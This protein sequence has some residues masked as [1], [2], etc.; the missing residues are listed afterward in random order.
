MPEQ[1]LATAADAVL[2][3]DDQRRL[4]DGNDA[5][6]ELLGV[7]YEQLLTMRIDDIAADE[8]RP[9][10]DRLWTQFLAARR[11]DGIFALRTATGEI[12]VVNYAALADFPLPGI[13][14]SR[15]RPLNGG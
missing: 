15:L 13:H 9:E 14:L 7:S 10:I 11:L 8:L 2:V 6:C 1:P 5:A 12:R 4:V 3:A